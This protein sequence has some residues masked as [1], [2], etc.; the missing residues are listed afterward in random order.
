MSFKA[1]F[2]GKTQLGSQPGNFS[3]LSTGSLKGC[4]AIRILVH[5]MTLSLVLQDD[6]ILMSPPSLYNP[7]KC[8]HQIPNCLLSAE[9]G[10]SLKM[11]SQDQALFEVTFQAS[12]MHSTWE[13]VT[14][15][16]PLGTG[17]VWGW[18]SALVSWILDA[19]SLAQA[20]WVT[21]RLTNPGA[22]IQGT[23][24]SGGPQ[25]GWDPHFPPPLPPGRA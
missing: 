8:P 10:T 4:V 22:H 16:R 13:F 5:P 18:G 14:S 19:W 11:K 1:V 2:L 12:G 25:R 9:I 3:P 7:P 6:P 21:V 15:H 24:A 20:T 17:S 23:P